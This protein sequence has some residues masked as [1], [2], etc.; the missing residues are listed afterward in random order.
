MPH[1]KY[2]T[3]RLPS[4]LSQQSCNS[5][6]SSWQPPASHSLS[7]PSRLFPLTVQLIALAL[8]SLPG[9]VYPKTH[10][11]RRPR[12]PSPSTSSPERAPGARSTCTPP[13]SGC[14]TQILMYLGTA[15][16]QFSSQL[17]RYERWLHFYGP[18][19]QLVLHVSGGKVPV[20]SEMLTIFVC[21][22]DVE[23][24]SVRIL[25]ITTG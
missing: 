22:S 1:D 3:T 24:G 4:I 6:P 10:S 23:F 19:C 20:R 17:R 25:C 12:V 15:L 16:T 9:P 18:P 21:S 8:R 14:F 13:V 7:R 11:A 5:S 2:K